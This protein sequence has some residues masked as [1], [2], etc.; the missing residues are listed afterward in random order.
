MKKHLGLITSI[1]TILPSIALADVQCSPPR[2]INDVF[3]CFTYG[4]FSG[5][6]P[7]LILVG[8]VTFLSGVLK[9]VRAGD[10]EEARDSGRQVMIYGVI[11]LFIMVSYW[12][13]VNILS[14][15]FFGHGAKIPNYLPT[16]Q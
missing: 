13:F 16:L 7:V 5:L 10:N 12:G 1:V 9:F 2:T 8:L 3:G 11:I 15:S 6:I 4:N 14:Q